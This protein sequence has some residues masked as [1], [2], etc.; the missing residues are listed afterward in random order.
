MVKINEDAQSNPNDP[1]GSIVAM[2]EGHVVVRGRDGSELRR[3]RPDIGDPFE[4]PDLVPDGWCYQWVAQ[5]VFGDRH[6]VTDQNMSMYE[7]GWRPV[8]CDRHPGR[9]LP[10]GTTGAVIR[11][12]QML[13]ERP[14]ALDDE[15]RAEE[16]AKARQLIKDRNASLGMEARRALPSDFDP[17][18]AV[19]GVRNASLSGRTRGEGARITIDPALD[20]PAPQ[21]ERDRG[22]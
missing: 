5:D 18:S 20:I 13:V 14:K 12:G 21:Y 8:P 7:N 19:S 4:C 3:S 22:D 11:G 9:F 16:Y 17:L 2:R 6:V 15:A 10:I 1:N